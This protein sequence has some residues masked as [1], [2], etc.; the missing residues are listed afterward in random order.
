[1]AFMFKEYY[2]RRVDADS[3]FHQRV[4]EKY[5]T[6]AIGDSYRSFDVSLP[7]DFAFFSAAAGYEQQASRTFITS[8]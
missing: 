4:P 7:L 6:E 1:M 5:A 3:H 2:Q 8:Q